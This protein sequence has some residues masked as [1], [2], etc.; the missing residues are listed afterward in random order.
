MSRP[1]ARRRLV[2]QRLAVVA[3]L[4]FFLAPVLWLLL[5]AYR[6]AS[7]VFSF[8]PRLAGRLTLENFRTVVGLFDLPRLVWSS[9]VISGGSTLIALLLGVPAGYALARSGL[10]WA[11]RIAYLFLAV[12]MVPPVATLI[13][14][15]LMMRDIGLLGSYGAVVLIDATQS[16]GFVVWMMFAYFRGVPRELEDAAFTEGCSQ[17][18]AFLRIALPLVGPGLIAS[19]LFCVLFSWNDFLFPAFLTTVATKPLSVALLS[20]YGTKDITWG[21]MGALAHFATLPVVALALW[22]NR[23]FIQGLTRGIH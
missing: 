9:I 23:Y 13:P 6:P 2:L 1:V 17:A 20:A 7:E 4:A 14:Y 15:Y 5:V 3:A 10:R 11:P 19:T 18:G 21:T 22:L 16:A 12:R 8:P